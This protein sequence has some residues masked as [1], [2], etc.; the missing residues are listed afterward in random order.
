MNP[1]LDTPIN[2]TNSSAPL[3]VCPDTIF[4]HHRIEAPMAFFLQNRT[5]VPIKEDNEPL[6]VAWALLRDSS[7]ETMAPS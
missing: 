1:R 3:Y 7:I 5:P 2:K 4:Q 6:Y